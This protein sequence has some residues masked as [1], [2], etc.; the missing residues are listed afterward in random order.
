MMPTVIYWEPENAALTEPYFVAIPDVTVSQLHR[1]GN[2]VTRH[3][4]ETGATVTDHI[5][6]EPD[7]LQLECF[8]TN[9]PVQYLASL[10]NPRDR[11]QR[12]YEKLMDLHVK[13]Y[14]STIITALR[15]YDQM[16]LT[17]LEA[18]RDSA[19]GAG[20]QVTLEFVRVSFAESQLVD[21]PQPT[22]ERA[23]PKKADG[24]QS[25][26]PASRAVENKSLLLK[27]FSAV[28]GS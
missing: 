28:A 21:A 15:E 8:W 13:G 1:S 19:T 3:P 12:E 25:K 26:K 11:A 2:T 4:I 9:T 18:P 23:K 22:V 24:R 27:A 14:L 10:R 6:A 5:A 7:G 20:V 17:R 16:A